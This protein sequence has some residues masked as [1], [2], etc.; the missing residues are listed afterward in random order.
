MSFWLFDPKSF[1]DSALFPTG[2]LG[3]FLNTLT[4]IVVGLAATIKTRFPEMMTDKNILLYT[5]VVLIVITATGYLFCRDEKSKS[6][7]NNIN[8]DL[9]YE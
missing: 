6:L 2:G 5:S 4:L 1:K 3:N 7:E 9:T 8:F